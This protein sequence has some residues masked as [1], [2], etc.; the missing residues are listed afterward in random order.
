MPFLPET[1]ENI[2]DWQKLVLIV[3][4]R[5][6][7]GRNSGIVLYIDSQ[8]DLGPC[9]HVRI[10]P[11]WSESSLSAWRKLGPLAL[12]WAHSKDSDKTVRRPRLI[13]VFAGR[14]CHFVGFVMR[15]LI[16]C[17]YS[18]ILLVRTH[19]IIVLLGNKKKSILFGCELALSWTMA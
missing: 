5:N 16:C 15:W 6:F 4:C 3:E 9:Q 2:W 1:L 17:G 19:D 14:T 10:C 13:R 12:S 18:E 7:S 11:V 8:S